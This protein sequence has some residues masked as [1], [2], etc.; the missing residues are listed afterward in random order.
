V[1]SEL[2]M[3]M[4]IHLLLAAERRR[5]RLQDSGWRGLMVVGRHEG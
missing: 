1:V 5:R 2:T 4:Y 3:Y